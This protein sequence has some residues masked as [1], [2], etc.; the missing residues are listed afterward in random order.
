MSPA[1][2]YGMPGPP[3]L[4]RTFKARLQINKAPHHRSKR[5]SVHSYA[6]PN[7]PTLPVPTHSPSPRFPR[8][9]Q[10]VRPPHVHPLETHAHVTAGFNNSCR[11]VQCRAC[12]SPPSPHHAPTPPSPSAL[13]CA[14]S[15]FHSSRF[16]SPMSFSSGLRAGCAASHALTAA[17]PYRSWLVSSSGTEPRNALTFSSISACLG[18]WWELRKGNLAAGRRGGRSRWV[19]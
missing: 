15:V 5:G 18:D 9:L 10:H 6:P 17:R 13:I 2:G 8:C 16:S 12:A 14:G 3:T 1:I 7:P 11:A 4:R 19:T